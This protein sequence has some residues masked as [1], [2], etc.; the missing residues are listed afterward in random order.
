MKYL[1]VLC[2]CGYLLGCSATHLDPAAPNVN[3]SKSGTDTTSDSSSNSSGSDSASSL[4]TYDMLQWM[5]MDPSLSADHHLS[6][7]ANPIYTTVLSDRFYW[8]KSGKGHPWDVKLYDDNYIYLWATEWDWHNPSTY[9]IF[10]SPKL[11][12]YNMPMVPRHAKGGFPGSRIKISDSTYE[13]HSSCTDYVTKSLGYVINELWGPYKETLGGSLP[14]NLETLVISYRYSCDASYSNCKH[15]EEF[16][17][18]KPYGLVK[19]QHQMLGAN[20]KYAAPDNITFINTLKAGQTRV[21]T[22]CF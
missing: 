1:V 12:N 9:K 17:V 8:T 19:W 3:N 2:L 15:K 7:T 11:G 21:V 22:S 18:A 5:T 14:D 20:G 16:H 4:D 6:G 10:H 13:I